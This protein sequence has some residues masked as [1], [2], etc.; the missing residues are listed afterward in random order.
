[1]LSESDAEWH[2]PGLDLP[3]QRW[4]AKRCGTPWRTKVWCYRHIQHLYNLRAE[5]PR[6][7]VGVKD[8]LIPVYCNKCDAW[9][10]AIPQEVPI[11]CSM[12]F[13]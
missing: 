1:M 4:I 2:T 11:Q 8:G 3:A 9:H 7:L 10:E 13:E 5:T 6:I 12:E